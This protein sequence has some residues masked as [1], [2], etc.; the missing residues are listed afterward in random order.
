MRKE[1]GSGGQRGAWGGFSVSPSPCLLGLYVEPQPSQV[2]EQVSSQGMGE[3]GAAKGTAIPWEGDILRAFY[4]AELLFPSARGGHGT[5]AAVADGPARSPTSLELKDP[6][7][8]L[9]G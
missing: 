4:P 8:A 7:T 6:L 5:T 1:G 9:T 2:S 3:V